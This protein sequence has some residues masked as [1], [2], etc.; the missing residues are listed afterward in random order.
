VLNNVH[1]HYNQNE[2]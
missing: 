2:V 1:Q